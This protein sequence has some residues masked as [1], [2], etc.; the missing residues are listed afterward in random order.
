MERQ[1]VSGP[2]LPKQIGPYLG[3]GHLAPPRQRG[4]SLTSCNDDA[5]CNAM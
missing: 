2:G 5:T 3:A 1:I 4:A